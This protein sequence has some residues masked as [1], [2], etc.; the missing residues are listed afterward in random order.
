[1]G[2]PC[3]IGVDPGVS[4]AWCVYDPKRK[5][6][7]EV[8][9]NPFILFKDKYARP[10]GDFDKFSSILYKYDPL[11]VVIEASQIRGTNSRRGVSGVWWYAA[12]VDT[13]FRVHNLDIEYVNPKDWQKVVLLEA[14]ST[15]GVSRPDKKYGNLH[16]QW[17]ELS[18]LYV[19][20]KYGSKVLVPK[21]GKVENDGF[22]DAICIAEY[23]AT[24]PVKGEER[25][26]S[27]IYRP[28]KAKHIRKVNK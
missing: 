28:R 20:K 7:L 6:I 16:E 23:A 9:K 25:E 15:L 17:K 27:W 3:V 4:G 8:H 24:L 21:G 2:T 26:R 5:K 11:L 10:V 14:L 19:A 18:K 1:M 22:S 13:L 12:I